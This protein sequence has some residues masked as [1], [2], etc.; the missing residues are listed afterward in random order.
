LFSF[1]FKKASDFDFLGG[2][3]NEEDF[4]VKKQ[5]IFIEL[6]DDMKIDLKNIEYCFL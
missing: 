3:E 6:P 2:R 4:S 5:D 1:N